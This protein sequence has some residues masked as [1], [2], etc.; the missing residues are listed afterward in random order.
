MERKRLAGLGASVAGIAALFRFLIDITFEPIALFN[1]I[2]G[3]SLL[4][5]GIIMF[6]NGREE[7]NTSDSQKIVVPATALLLFVS[8]FGA[9]VVL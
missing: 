7:G 2:I 8:G 4:T 9:Y 3:I 6:S 1:G 5:L